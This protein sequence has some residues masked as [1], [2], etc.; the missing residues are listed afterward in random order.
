MK[1]FPSSGRGGGRGIRTPLHRSGAGSTTRLYYTP[2]GKP[3]PTPT[4]FQTSGESRSVSRPCCRSEH[5][6]AS[7][8]KAHCLL[9]LRACFRRRSF[10]RRHFQRWLPA[11]FQAREPRFIDPPTYSPYMS[12]SGHSVGEESGRYRIRTRVLGLEIQ[13]DIQATLIARGSSRV[14]DLLQIT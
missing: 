9:A 8:K 3:R 14:P 12:K 7:E 1:L 13:G 11:F 6:I 4:L 10:L 5:R 2:K